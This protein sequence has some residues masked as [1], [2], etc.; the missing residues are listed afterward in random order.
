MMKPKYLPASSSAR[1]SL[2]PDARLWPGDERNESATTIRLD[3]VL[4]QCAGLG[5]STL[6][7]VDTPQPLSFPG[8]QLTM[9]LECWPYNSLFKMRDKIFLCVVDSDI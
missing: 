6:C 4:R 3:R 5:S 8:E 9:L 1:G 2:P 7:D